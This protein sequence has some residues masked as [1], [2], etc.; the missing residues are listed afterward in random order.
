[1]AV[2]AKNKIYLSIIF[3]ILIMSLIYFNWP[4]KG[5]YKHKKLA[6]AFSR[7]RKVASD[8]NLGDVK[9]IILTTIK[10]LLT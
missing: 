7:E 3:I 2:G 9:L 6:L 5:P 8:L 4:F 10:S 1:M